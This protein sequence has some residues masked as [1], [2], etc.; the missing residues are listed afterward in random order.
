MEEYNLIIDRKRTVW[1]RDTVFV[2]AESKDE[3][4]T[5]FFNGDYINLKD[6]EILYSM[7]TD[8]SSDATLE[9]YCFEENEYEP[10]YTN[11]KV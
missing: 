6:T 9:I 2:N 3:A 8:I 1:C 4:I 11:K 7:P 10:I 5:K